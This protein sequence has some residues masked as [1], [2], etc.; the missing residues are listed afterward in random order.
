MN[1]KSQL[2]TIA[3]PVANNSHEISYNSSIHLQIVIKKDHKGPMFPTIP[4]N[5]HPPD[6]LLWRILGNCPLNV[7]G[8]STKLEAVTYPKEALEDLHVKKLRAV[9][10]A[11]SFNLHIQYK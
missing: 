11:C 2:S 4:N 6:D 9:V 3:C 5:C 8:N 10:S 7:I 1:P